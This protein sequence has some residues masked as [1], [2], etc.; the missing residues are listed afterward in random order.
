VPGGDSEL[1][2]IT[3]D[4]DLSF[5]S[6]PD[7]EALIDSDG[8]ANLNVIVQVTDGSNVVQSIVDIAVIDIDE[9]VQ[10][11]EIIGDEGRN[12]L[13]GT[14]SADTIRSF[15]G[16]YDRSIGGLGADCFQFGMAETSNGRRERDLLRDYN[17]EEDII[18]L[19]EGLEI[20]QARLINGG[21]ALQLSGDRDMIY[22]YG[23]DLSIEDVQIEYIA[24]ADLIGDGI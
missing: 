12:Q 20:I 14:E 11:N 23:P 5:R 1:F 4:G 3:A 18:Q 24:S 8:D 10:K 16:A 22:V 7:Y 9:P 2:A 15:G 21:V 19:E 17:P 13:L 6:A